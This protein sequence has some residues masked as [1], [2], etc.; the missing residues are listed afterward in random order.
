MSESQTLPFS[1]QTG[2]ETAGAVLLVSHNFPPLQGAESL[3]V[4]HN[5]IDL[6]SRGWTVGVV[7]SPERHGRSKTDQML[8]DQIPSD[9]QV[10]RTEKAG[11]LTHQGMGKMLRFLLGYLET[12]LLPCPNLF[13]KNQAALLGQ[14]WMKGRAPAII[15]SRAP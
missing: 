4:R 11:T 1:R 12:Q 3:L 9:I 5:T 6:H 14:Q 15:Y 8:L 13:W 10:M 2:G 7:T